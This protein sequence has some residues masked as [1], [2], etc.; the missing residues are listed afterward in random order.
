[1]I[2]V[3]NQYLGHWVIH[4]RIIKIRNN[5]S[6]CKV[7]FSSAPKIGT[8]IQPLFVKETDYFKM[9]T[10][11]YWLNLYSFNLVELWEQVTRKLISY[12]NINKTL[13]DND[14]AVQMRS[15]ISIKI[16]LNISLQGATYN[17][18]KSQI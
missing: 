6:T 9:K 10:Y 3:N 7:I 5:N 13:D 12:S 17:V 15:D 18:I 11:E 16:Q 4:K 8:K 1:M 2:K 14:N